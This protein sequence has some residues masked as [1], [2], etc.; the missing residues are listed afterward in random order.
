MIK[1]KTVLWLK[2]IFI[3]LSSDSLKVHV[4]CKFKKFAMLL[5]QRIMKNLR[6]H[7]E[8]CVYR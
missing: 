5:H 2:V 8:C 7:Q 1:M 4:F 3:P 6:L